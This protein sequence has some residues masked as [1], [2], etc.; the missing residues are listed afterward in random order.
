VAG[1]FVAEVEELNLIRI[2]DKH[3]L[4]LVLQTLQ[5]N[6]DVVLSVNISQDT[7]LDPEWLSAL[8]SGLAAIQSGAS[9]LIVEITE[10]MAITN[11]EETQR[12]LKNLKA[13][14]C[15]VAIDDFGAGFTSFSTLKKLPVDII[16]IDGSFAL[17]LLDSPENQAFIKALLSLAKVFDIETVVEWVEDEVTSDILAGWKVDYQQGHQFGKPQPV[18]P[19]AK[20]SDQ[21]DCR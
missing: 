20:L 4:K 15:R 18:L 13:I 21:D 19:G 1:D 16:K 7:V 14:G 9:R 8:A 2:L 6:H 17:N 10:S 11:L 12:F 3:A 5:E